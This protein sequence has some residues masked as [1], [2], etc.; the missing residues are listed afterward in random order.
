[1][2][3][4]DDAIPRVVPR[5]LRGVQELPDVCRLYELAGWGSIP[6]ETMERMFFQGPNGPALI[7]VL[8]DVATDQI[9]GMMAFTPHRVQ[10][11]ETREIGSRSRSAILDPSLRRKAT[12]QIAG[13][14]DDP[15]RI[16]IEASLP[17]RLDRGWR[18]SFTLPNPLFRKRRAGRAPD[19]ARVISFI[20]L[21]HQLRIKLSESTRTVDTIVAVPANTPAGPEYDDLWERAR[22]NVPIQNAV[23]RDA[24]AQRG[25]ASHLRLELR[26]PRTG[27]LRGYMRLKPDKGGRLEDIL[28]EDSETFDELIGSSV[29]W[30]NS[31]H[32]RHTMRKVVS[33][34]H[35]A[36]ADSLRRAGATERDYFFTFSVRCLDNVV[37]PHSDAANWYV[38]MGD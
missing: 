11:G 21:G 3:S 1:M 38:T 5:P 28:A 36:F 33:L 20:D 31:N 2:T 18:I 8:A 29:A 9:M 25:L 7:M 35:P 19:P 6:V 24:Q 13:S 30:L 22:Q 17:H 23:V 14:D 26:N 37:G 32:D 4:D 15:L 27:A 10:I 34:P 16:L 12:G